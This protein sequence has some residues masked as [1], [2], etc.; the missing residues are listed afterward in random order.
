MD[1]EGRRR[2]HKCGKDA[3]PAKTFQDCLTICPAAPKDC[4]TRFWQL[5]GN[6]ENPATCTATCSMTHE[7]QKTF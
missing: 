7:G 5:N 6:A 3:V 2:G 1:D 4:L